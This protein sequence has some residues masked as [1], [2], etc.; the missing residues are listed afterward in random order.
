[1]SMMMMILIWYKFSLY[2]LMYENRDIP[3]AIGRGM[4]LSMARAQ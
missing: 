4:N 3:H 1:M 2:L